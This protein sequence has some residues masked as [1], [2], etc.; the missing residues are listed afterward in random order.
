M[1]FLPEVKALKSKSLCS[2]F[3]SGTAGLWLLLAMCKIKTPTYSSYFEKK[4]NVQIYSFS[5]QNISL[6]YPE[7]A[8]QSPAPVIFATARVT[9]VPGTQLRL[10]LTSVQEVVYYEHIKKS[11]LQII[12]TNDK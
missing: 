7:T 2:F 11:L 8:L 4:I 3:H 6:T 9:S 10:L 12:R 1:K 5:T